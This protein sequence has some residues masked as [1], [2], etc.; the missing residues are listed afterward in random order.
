MIPAHIRLYA[1]RAYE[2]MLPARITQTRRASSQ[3]QRV[4]RT[5]WVFC[6][7]VRRIGTLICVSIGVPMWRMQSTERLPCV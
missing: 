6:R 1:I 3:Y 2:H 7:G 4:S 5:S